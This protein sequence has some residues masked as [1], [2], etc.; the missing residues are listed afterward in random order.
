MYV[1]VFPHT[2]VIKNNFSWI[3]IALFGNEECKFE[4]FLC[5][6]LTKLLVSKNL[7]MA[8]I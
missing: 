4:Y 8:Y 5:I 7:A 6:F 2:L 1:S 3:F